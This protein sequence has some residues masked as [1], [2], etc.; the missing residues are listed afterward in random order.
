M[1]FKKIEFENYKTFY[2][3]QSIDLYIPEEVRKEG[4]N[5]ILLGG[6]NGTGK[7]TILKAILYV[8][9]KRRGMSEQEYKQLFS[10]AI[11][12]TFFEEG[13]KTA[14]VTLTI[15]T[16]QL[17]EWKLKVKWYFDKEK[18]VS[19]EEQEISIIPPGSS[20]PKKIRVENAEAYNKV[21]DKIIPYHAAPFFIFDG[22]EIKEVIL[23]Q[24]SHEMKEAIHKISGLDA[25]KNLSADLN[26]LKKDIEN[27]IAKSI[28]KN[29]LD[30]YNNKL[31][32]LDDE[33][34]KHQITINE[35]AN[36]KSNL[37]TKLNEVKAI[38]NDKLSQN[39]KS[40]E[41][42]IK[43][44]TKNETLLKTKEE[45]FID[46]FKKHS[47]LII[48]NDKIK[49]LKKS[50]N[51]EK[52]IKHKK[53]LQESSLLPYNQFIDELLNLKIEPPLTQEQF[54]QIKAM[55]KD[56]WARQNKINDEVPEDFKE[57][58]D[59][60][61]TEFN[62]LNNIP[63][64]SRHSIIEKINS[65]ENLKNELIQSENEI[66][67]APESVNIVEENKRIENLTKMIGEI[68]LELRSTN[69]E[70]SKL[71]D[72][73]TSVMNKLTRMSGKNVDIEEIQ[74]EYDLLNKVIITVNSYLEQ[75]TEMKANFIK[76][77][78]SNMLN[79][80]LRK[81]DE[82]SNIEFDME[83]YTIRL[84]NDH[85]QEISI[86]DR[87][88]GEM[89]IISS[90]LIWALTKSS[91]L[92]LP[93]IVDTPLGRLDSQHRNH[94]INNYYKNLSEQVVIL[95]T[96]TEITEEYIN[97]MQRNSYKQYN[98]DYDEAKK[99]TVIRDGYFNFVKE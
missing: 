91:V 30:K 69:I 98:L 86:H 62:T 97:L 43:K 80:L 71:R 54:N 66:K 90:A 15:E 35:L 81:E 34:T 27:E 2:G 3:T 19:H 73:K 14:S 51:Y 83:T 78:F 60:S 44:I 63:L 20:R 16:D 68:N 89:Q 50:L 24:R 38:K 4:K 79:K 10:N 72:K 92:T 61:N 6:L 8:L 46:V 29:Q 32:N 41:Q 56:I 57:I 49:K 77:E 5:I 99:Y 82:F 88:A 39:S 84:Y 7:T 96:D 53:I 93:I 76:D 22:V 74:K 55:G 36:R 48:L 42:I 67:N 31:G 85:Q 26:L 65:I 58:H 12:N 47:V 28:N 11:N 9:F 64:I 21:I 17:E 75:A 87:S 52:D 13:G 70:L 94:L 40:R 95:S 1:L 18:K 37:E 45:E 59:V 25:Y 23:R 33:I